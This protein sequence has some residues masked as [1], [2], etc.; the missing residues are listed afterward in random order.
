[1]LQPLPVGLAVRSCANRRISATYL[2][3]EVRWKAINRAVCSLAIAISCLAGLVACGSNGG[4]KGSYGDRPPDYERALAAA[5]KPLAGLYDQANR[6]LPGGTDAFQ[7][8]IAA[9]RGYPVV[10]NQW[11]SWCG[12]CREEFP[13]LQ[14]ASARFGTRVAFL[15]VDSQDSDDA[16]STFLG[17]FPVP[18]PSYTDPEQDI[19][20]LLEASRGLPDMSYYDRHGNLVFTRQ[21]AYA[22]QSELLADIHR[23][24]LGG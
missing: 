10:V 1:L 14:R 17:E 7:R 22:G 13:W 8:R 15:G 24:A 12:P 11:A 5:P 9:L 4:G 18:Y 20:R 19:G 21:G 23:Y 16:A 3:T 2:I 6:L